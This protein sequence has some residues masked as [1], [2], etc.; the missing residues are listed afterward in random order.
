MPSDDP[1]DVLS[2][3]PESQTPRLEVSESSPPT[4]HDG[5]NAFT[6]HRQ[7]EKQ[8]SAQQLRT[9]RAKI[10]DRNHLHPY[11]Q[12]LSLSN[13]DSCVALENA[14][15]PEAERCSREKFIYRLTTCPELCLGLFSSTPSNSPNASIPTYPTARPADSASPAMKSV[16][17]AM[18]IS[19]K[20]ISPTVTD[21]SMDI[22]PNWKANPSNTSI[23]GHRE[24][25]R[26][27]AIHSLS[28]LPAFQGKG[29][30]KTTMRSYQQRM[31]TS[32][33][34]NRIALLAHDHLV[35]MYEGMGFEGKG[36][37]DVRLAG[38]GWNSLIYEFA[39]HG[40]GS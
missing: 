27:I 17:I 6:I 31:E 1:P 11:V 37:S 32:G 40:P 12:T 30:G 34:A 13:L 24:D 14:V 16:L 22:A 20:T 25:G 26:T 29:L 19:T 7:E 33:V 10:N 5:Y 39:E 36:K 15:F 18:V 28:V 4:S 35:N 3:S 21:E 9:N 8:T 23:H 2:D 38:G